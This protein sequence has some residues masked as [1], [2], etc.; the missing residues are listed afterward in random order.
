MIPLPTVYHGPVI[1]P[2]S[3]TAYDALPNCLL[4]VSP[5]GDIAW[6]VDDV[7]GPMVQEVLRQK[8]CVHAE[9]I[10]LKVGE[11]LIPGFVDTHTHAPQLPN[12]GI[13]GQYELLDWLEKCTFPM[14]RK[15]ADVAF[16]ERTYRSVVR[17]AIDC[18]TTTCC[19]Y[20]TLHLEATK[21]LAD[22]L[23]EKGQRAFVGKC[24]MD[25]N[26]PASYVEPSAAQSLADTHALIAH[27]RAHPAPPN[28]LSSAARDPAPLVQPILTPRFAISCTP[29]LLAALGTLAARDPA[30]RIQT[31]ISEN[32]KE[33]AFTKEL[34]PASA[35][36]AGVYDDFGLLRGNTILA[37]GVHLEEAE[38]A[39]IR[40]RGAGISHCP[41]SNFNLS[42]GVAPVG[43]Y[44]DRGIKVG[45]GTDVSGGFSPSIL[46]VIQHASIAAK[47]TSFAPS[48]SPSADRLESEPG[49]A[50][51]AGKQLPIATLFYLATMGG[52]Q[53][54]CMDDRI[55]SFAVGKAFDALLVN[56]G[57][58]AGNPALWCGLDEAGEGEGA[59]SNSKEV[60]DG[61]LERF[62]FCGDDRNIERVFVQGRFIG[63]KGFMQ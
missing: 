9:V 22:I 16:A 59:N 7:Q 27:I 10:T 1:N 33:V 63:G 4:A 36:Y 6:L 55:G 62:L 47:V 2:R 14:E 38:L 3:L 61:M 19:Y 58:S 13:G 45:L 12:L 40:A 23:N 15:F 18:G 53:V 50:G 52:A 20:G 43:K 49:Q 39:L 24:N 42:S 21:K 26:C 34:F 11:F 31:H 46:T 17:R 30:L 44:L 41:T 8:G 28:I 48:P 54:C 56:V 25:R 29:D 57:E 51:F 5:A 37:H 60:L 32:R 35:S